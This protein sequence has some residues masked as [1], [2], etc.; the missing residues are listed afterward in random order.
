MMKKQTSS[1]KRIGTRNESSSCCV[2]VNAY[3]CACVCACI[4]VYQV[5]TTFGLVVTSI[6]LFLAVR[7]KSAQIFKTIIARYGVLFAP[8]I[9]PSRDFPLPKPRSQF[10]IH[11]WHTSSVIVFS[12]VIIEDAGERGGISPNARKMPNTPLYPCVFPHDLSATNCVYFE[13]F[14]SSVNVNE[15]ICGGKSNCLYVGQ[16]CSST[17]PCACLAISR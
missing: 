6:R 1:V 14:P 5:S 17:S 7:V 11:T 12:Q 3:I 15:T 9:G 13:T 10:E 8:T 2:S 4:R 16:F